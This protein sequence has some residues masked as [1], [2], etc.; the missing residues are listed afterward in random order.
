M[1]PSSI[2]SSFRSSRYSGMPPETSNS[3][4][5]LDRAVVDSPAQRYDFPESLVGCQLSVCFRELKPLPM[6][7]FQCHFCHEP[8]LTEPIDRQAA[9]FRRCR[10]FGIGFFLGFGCLILRKVTV[11]VDFAHLQVQGEPR[12]VEVQEREF[13][14]NRGGIQHGIQ[15]RQLDPLRMDA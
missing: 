5:G 6:Q 2:R 4:L 13:S 9:W 12:P 1:R 14:P 7:A 11:Q 15:S 8:L 10:T 3:A